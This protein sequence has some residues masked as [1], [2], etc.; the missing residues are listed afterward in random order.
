MLPVEVR[1]NARRE[2]GPGTAPALRPW[3]QGGS[4]FCNELRNATFAKVAQGAIR[5]GGPVN[6]ARH[7]IHHDMNP[8][9]FSEG[10]MTRLAGE[11]E[12]LGGG[13]AL[14]VFDHLHALDLS[15]HLS[16]QT[17]AV[18]RVIDRGTRGISFILN[19]MVFNVVPTALEIGL[20]S[21]ILG[22]R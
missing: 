3:A 16:R 8:R 2:P 15:F 6:N 14:R 12:A 22:T 5:G 1:H 17:G 11:C 18:T 9:S 13:V 4:S 19:S 7:V 20:V 21:Y 10:R